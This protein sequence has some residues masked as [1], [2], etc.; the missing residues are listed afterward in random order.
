ML[1]P[2]AG[3]LSMEVVNSRREAQAAVQSSSFQQLITPLKIP[4]VHDGYRLL[5]QVA[6]KIIAGKNRDGK[7]VVA[8]IIRV[9]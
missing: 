9:C 2:H 6:D 5:S 3:E 4:G 1:L 8:N 7:L